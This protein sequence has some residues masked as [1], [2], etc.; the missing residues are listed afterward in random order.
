[1]PRSRALASRPR[2]V[3]TA[4]KVAAPERMRSSAAVPEADA[5]ARYEAEQSKFGTPERRTIQ[6]I[7]FPNDAGFRRPERALAVVVERRDLLLGRRRHLAGGALGPLAKPDAVPEADARAR[8]EAEQSKFGT[9]E[10]RTI[11]QIVFPSR[12]SS[13]TVRVSGARNAPLRSL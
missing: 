9:P 1:V 6:Q 7:V 2:S 3:A 5:R 12:T 11:Q 4:S 10:R 13:E 8:Y